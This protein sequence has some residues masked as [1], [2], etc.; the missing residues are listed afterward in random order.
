MQ[1]HPSSLAGT[2]LDSGEISLEAVPTP[3]S[4]QART[5]PAGSGP[6]S[7]TTATFAQRP[8][9]FLVRVVVRLLKRLVTGSWKFL[10]VAGLASLALQP[11]AAHASGETGI[12]LP[13]VVLLA[14][15]MAGFAAMRHAQHSNNDAWLSGPVLANLTLFFAF[16]VANPEGPVVFASAAFA[17]GYGIGSVL[18]LAPYGRAG[19]HEG[20]GA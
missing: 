10:L 12:V 8:I 1:Y 3:V 11:L 17:L 6:A 20:I 18:A 15:L 4:D 16:S 13:V 9:T 7:F 2:D 5:E 14:G 19:N